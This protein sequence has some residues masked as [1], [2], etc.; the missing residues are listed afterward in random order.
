MDVLMPQL[1][2][3]VAEGKIVKWFKSAGDAVKPGE[4]LFEIETDKTS[5]EVPAIAAGTLSDIRF[6][7]GEVAKVGAVVAVIAGA[8]G[9]QVSAPSQPVIPVKPT[10]S[11]LTPAKA[12]VQSGSKKELDPRFRGDD[13]SMLRGNERSGG[14]ATGQASIA[15]RDLA[16][17]DMSPWREVRTP[18]RN[19]GPAKIGGRQITPLARRLA[20]ERGIDLT[21]VAGSGPHGRIVAADISAAPRTGEAAPAASQF[22]VIADIEIGRLLAMREEAKTAGVEFSIGD[23]AVKAWAAAQRRV[24]PE[25]GADVALVHIADG[26]RV[27]KVIR[28]A[29]G[30]SL[31][32][33][34]R[35]APG[36]SGNGAP[37]ASVTSAVHVLETP[38][39]RE[40][41]SAVTPPFTSVLAIGQPRRVP[42]EAEGGGVR[43]VSEMTATLSCDARAIDDA[44]AAGL[45]AV[46][47][48]FVENPVTALI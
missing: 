39:I 6:Q 23:F 44:Q 12:G 30:K 15:A 43:F 28:D 32:T 7:V 24:A 33:I 3:T 27:T 26:G 25:A 37:D 8:G 18:E 21:R 20:S 1:G 40:F 36:D 17:P 29:A 48:A 16:Y 5:M 2:E 13:R 11:P 35:E 46:F 31:S 45:L 9:E 10:P 14:Q 41:S 47:K 4:N 19:Y 42:V 34:A 22:H 38:G